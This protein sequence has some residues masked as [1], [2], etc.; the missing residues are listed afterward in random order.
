MAKLSA[1]RPAVKT[2]KLGRHLMKLDVP[3]VMGIL[4]MTPDSF[5]GDGIGNNMSL[6]VRKGREMFS[7][8]ADLV[9]I[10][11]EST[12]PGAEPVT[13]RLE[14]ARIMGVIESLAPDFP[15]RVSVDTMKP[16]VAEIALQSGASIVNDVAGLRNARMIDV[17]AKHGASTIIMHMKGRPRTMQQRPSY[18]DVVRE[19]KDYLEQRV[20][21]AENGGI[22]PR[23]IMVDPGIGFG[24]T[25]GNNLEI[26]SRLREFKS[27]GKPI[28]IGVS[29]KSFIGK[30]TG[31]LA[32]ERIEGSI[33]AAV[34]AVKEGANIVR[35]HDVKETARALKV[36]HE[37]LSVKPPK[38]SS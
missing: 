21:A 33:A 25:V 7:S 38:K 30:I 11:G 8:G 12:R 23:A 1:D 3:R 14:I 28:V 35:V 22:D 32:E 16:E 15:G 24:K 29:R 26:I 2:V 4:N 6:G 18:R 9:D 34:L 36:A 17:I 13:A 19:V 37:I 20:E 27:I 10:G 31:L 5:S